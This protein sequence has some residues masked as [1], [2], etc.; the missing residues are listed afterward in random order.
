MTAREY[1]DIRKELTG[2]F[3]RNTLVEGAKERLKFERDRASYEGSQVKAASIILDVLGTP[4]VLK[5]VAEAC[6]A[7]LN[8]RAAAEADTHDEAAAQLREAVKGQPC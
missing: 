4:P 6:I 1:T 2:A 5:A 8:R 3:L 7:E